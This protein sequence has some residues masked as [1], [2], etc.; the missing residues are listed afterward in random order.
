MSGSL[1][2]RR[3]EELTQSNALSPWES[4]VPRES[5]R[6]LWLLKFPRLKRFLEEGSTKGKKSS[7]V[8]QRSVNRMSIDV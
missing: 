8:F 5:Q 7:T 6:G 1:G 3:S 4:E 2:G